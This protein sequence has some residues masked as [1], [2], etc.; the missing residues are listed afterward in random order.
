MGPHLRTCTP[1]PP[2]TPRCFI[3]LQ[4]QLI[5]INKQTTKEQQILRTHSKHTNSYQ[6]DNKY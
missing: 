1:V 4:Q 2:T 6:T 3:I 5:T